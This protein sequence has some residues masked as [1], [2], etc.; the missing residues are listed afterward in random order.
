[1]KKGLEIYHDRGYMDLRH[2]L[3]QH[4]RDT[5]DE[6]IIRDGL[7]YRRKLL[8]EAFEYTTENKEL[9]R[10][11]CT[12]LNNSVISLYRKAWPLYETMVGTGIT[13]DITLVASFKM[14]YP[15]LH[16][17]QDTEEQEVWNALQTWRYN[18]GI[19]GPFHLMLHEG[20]QEKYD[21]DAILQLQPKD[22]EWDEELPKEWDQ[23]LPLTM[24]FHHWHTHSYYSLYDLIYVRDITGNIHVE[25]DYINEK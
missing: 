24:L 17:I 5:G 6:T 13:T 7:E 14:T 23:D 18:P 15:M 3:Y 10:A 12:R 16:P 25:L 4:L 9:L 21:E 11:F 19:S 8:E 2:S 20:H 1:M 22:E